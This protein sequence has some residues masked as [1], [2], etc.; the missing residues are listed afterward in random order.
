M[1][2]NSNLVNSF[3]EPRRS[4]YRKITHNNKNCDN[5]CFLQTLKTPQN[6]IVKSIGNL[7]LA[8]A[9]AGSQYNL[10]TSSRGVLGVAIAP[11]PNAPWWQNFTVHG[12]RRMFH[13]HLLAGFS[14]QKLVVWLTISPSSSLQLRR[15]FRTPDV[16][17]PFSQELSRQFVT[18]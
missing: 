18:F 14:H 5:H 13:K 15:H 10:S 7:S 16:Q 11:T 8:S 1:T 2:N 17:L 6:K 12:G 9:C 4:K 3:L